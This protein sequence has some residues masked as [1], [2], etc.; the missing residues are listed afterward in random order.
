MLRK[1][2]DR[3]SEVIFPSHKSDKSLADQFACFSKKNKKIEDTFVC[4]GTKYDVQPPF[5]PPKLTAFT[6]VFEYAVDKIIRGS[7]TKSCQLDPW[8]TFL[9]KECSD[10]LLLSISKLI[11]CSHIEVC[12]P[13]GFKTALVTPVIKNYSYSE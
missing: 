7:P 6:Q 13:D 12:V 4:L 10:I 8:P 1:T 11:N 5:D 9:I 2:P 3:V